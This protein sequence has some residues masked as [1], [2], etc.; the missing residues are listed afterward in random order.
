MSISLTDTSEAGAHACIAGS[1]PD[2]P[3]Q[4]TRGETS[5]P[6]LAHIDWLAFTVHP[7]QGRNWCWL[8]AVLEDIFNIPANTWHGTGRKWSGYTHRVDLIHPGEW[9]ER[10]PL[11]L[12]AYGGESQRG[13]MHASLNAQACAR[14]MDW[15]RVREWGDSVAAVITRVDAA[16]DDFEGK[17]VT[18]EQARTWYLEGQFSSNG[19]PPAAELVDDLGSGKGKT[20]YIGHRAYGKLARFYEKGK[21]EGD[22]YSPWLRIEVEWRNKN[23]TIP[24][25]IVLNTGHYLAGAY[26]C[27]QYLS[28]KQAK[29][30]TLQRAATINYE[31]MVK[32]LRTSAGKGL[33]VMLLVEGDAKSVLE[34][35]RRDG[36]PK[37]LEPYVGLNDAMPVKNEG[38]SGITQGAKNAHNGFMAAGFTVSVPKMQESHENAQP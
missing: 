8:R 24:W 10:V 3:V 28:I 14:I 21:K 34:K 26:P 37:R 5:T 17:T 1:A 36:A 27:L 4:V 7:D 30:K 25:D 12:V 31:H 13:T 33:N 23:R 29:I 35:V 16:H 22:P 11:G 2:S 9:G 20:F 19:R 15:H 32:W 6:H 18:I 38:A